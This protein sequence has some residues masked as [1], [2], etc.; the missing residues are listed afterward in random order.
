MYNMQGGD[1]NTVI[2]SYAGYNFET[3]D[4]NTFVGYFSGKNNSTRNLNTF[5]GKNAG[6]YNTT[7]T[8]N[9]LIGNNAG[10]SLAG[11]HTLTNSVAIGS[12]AWV[13]NSNH[14]I[15][16]NNLLNVGIGLSDDATGPRAKLEINDGT[17]GVSGLQFRT[18]T[19]AFTPGSTAT[20]FLT[21][22]IDGKVIMK[23]IPGSGGSVMACSTAAI[24]YLPKWSMISPTN[25]LCKSVV[26]EDGFSNVGISTTSPAQK[27]D[28]NGNCNLS[29]PD[30]SYFIENK[31]FLGTGGLNNRNNVELGYYAGPSAG[32]NGIDNI[33]IGKYTGS[34]FN[35]YES[36]NIFIGTSA[37][38]K[39]NGSFSSNTGSQ[40]VFIG[41][42]SGNFLRSENNYS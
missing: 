1:R 38:T 21:V 23:D 13:R 11:S 36:F 4:D 19:S 9:T 3:G 6:Q 10:E 40:N 31:R 28:V 2:G 33:L 24:G 14:M 16:G 27:L 42:N 5:V 41:L 37:G 34:N 20:K 30:Q 26:F 25:E 22:D 32:H 17:N 18:L 8:E 15:L 35:N 12:G 39:T 29:K 7:G